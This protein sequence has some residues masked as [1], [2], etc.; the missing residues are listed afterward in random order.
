MLIKNKRNHVFVISPTVSG[1]LR[2]LNLKS[3][4]TA[5][6]HSRKNQALSLNACKP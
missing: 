3:Q 2:N 1:N 6:A 5:R 4:K